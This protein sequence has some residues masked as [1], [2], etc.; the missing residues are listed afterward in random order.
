MCGIGGFSLFSKS[1]LNFNNLEKILDNIIHRGPDDQGM[2]KDIE[3]RIG[4]VH[5]R[6]SIQDL[7]SSGHQPM[8]SDDKQVA[9]VFNGEIYTISL[10]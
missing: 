3:N 8:V 5:S 6:L 4:L 10:S 9:L 7:S 2:Y 1:S